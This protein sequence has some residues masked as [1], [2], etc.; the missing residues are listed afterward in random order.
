[1]T[2]NPKKIAGSL[3]RRYGGRP[4][5][6]VRK[7]I[8]D[9][10]LL[11]D[12]IRQIL[13]LRRKAPKPGTA[14]GDFYRKYY[15]EGTTPGIRHGVFCLFD[16][17]LDHGGVTDRLKGILST[18]HE[19]RRRSLPFYVCW[20][21]PFPLE[22]YLVPARVDWRVDPGEVSSLRGDAFPVLIDER[23]NWQAHANNSLRLKM[24]LHKA[25]PQTQVYSNADNFR[26]HYTELYRELF[27]PS[28]LLLNAVNR[29]LE[30]L[31]GE[32]YAFS[33]RFIGLL[34]AFSDYPGIV[35]EKDEAEELIERVIA[36]FRRLAAEVPADARILITS[37]STVFL[38]RVAAVDE[39]IYIVP[40]DVKHIDFDSDISDDV[41]LKIFVDQHLLM[42]ARKVTLMRTGRMYRSDF[43]RFA[44]EIGGADFEC[45]E[46]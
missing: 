25:L 42:H 10:L 24:A 18:Y 36:E 6:V 46:F 43:P 28:E 3:G 31:G 7:F 11:P 23:I 2:L 8:Y 12:Q 35:L 15:S 41:W 26:G 17:R 1:M 32:Y 34:G 30:V 16:G 37:D 39:R 5:Q 14:N 22:D 40:G 13:Q 38:S 44:A 33:F 45:H 4:F 20:T 9:T 29:H 27:R 19:A 21:V